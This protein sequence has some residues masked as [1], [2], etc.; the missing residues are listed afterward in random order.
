M[1]NQ[2]KEAARKDGDAACVARRTDIECGEI[3]ASS[4]TDE[5][6]RRSVSD[7]RCRVTEAEAAEAREGFPRGNPKPQTSTG[8]GS[9]GEDLPTDERRGFADCQSHLQPRRPCSG[10]PRPQM[11]PDEANQDVAPDGLLVRADAALSLQ[12]GSRPVVRSDYEVGSHNVAL[13]KVHDT[14]AIICIG[15]FNPGIFHPAWLSARGLIQKLE[16]D[17]AEVQVVT[18]DATQFKIKW[19]QIQVL[20]D[21][22]SAA[23]DT[24]DDSLLLRDLVA[25]A[26]NFLEH[27]PVKFVGLNRNVHFQ[28][29]NESEWHHVGHVLAPKQIWRK[30]LGEPGLG[31]LTIKDARKDHDGRKPA[32]VNV[33]VSPS[34]SRLLT[35]EVAVNHHYVL[36]EGSAGSAAAHLVADQWETSAKAALDL[37]R[38]VITDALSA[39]EHD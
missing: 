29:A 11:S 25:G 9:S 24:P 14:A 2:T 6:R 36:K 18:Q 33:Q 28:L 12:C 3:T 4:G 27:T 20:R 34:T 21:R 5:E 19:L 38:G 7:L 1:R 23:T 8:L 39:K 30:Y 15:S 17:A 22:F 35:V 31:T 37:A 16:E 26:F 13:T 32:E 10:S